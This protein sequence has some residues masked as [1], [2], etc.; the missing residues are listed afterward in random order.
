MLSEA[1][2]FQDIGTWVQP[3]W[4]AEEQQTMFQGATSAVVAVHVGHLW[5]QNPFLELHF[6]TKY[7]SY[8][9]YDWLHFDKMFSLC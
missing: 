5:R 2:V 9:W 3:G 1:A 7:M 4:P 6:F 8:Y